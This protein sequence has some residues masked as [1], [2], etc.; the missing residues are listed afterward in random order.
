MTL[1]PKMIVPAT[2]NTNLNFYIYY[3]VLIVKGYE[4][5]F[6]TIK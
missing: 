4:Y 3:K 5:L 2:K 1:N 6:A